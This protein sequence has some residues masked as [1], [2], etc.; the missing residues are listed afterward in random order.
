L[1]HLFNRLFTIPEERLEDFYYH[2]LKF[3]LDRH[4]QGEE[5]VF[6]QYLWENISAQLQVLETK[7]VYDKDHIRNIMNAERLKR[8]RWILSSLD[9]WNIHSSDQPIIERQEQK[10]YALEQDIIRLRSELKVATSLDTPEYINIPKGRV[11][12]VLDL[13]I[14][15]SDLKVEGKELVF[16]E[17]SIVWVKMICK[18]FR[19]DHEDIKFDRVRRYFPEDK[20]NPSARS[21]PI[22]SRQSLFEIKPIRKR[23]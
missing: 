22:P 15:L 7:D 10:I 6:F 2:H 21:A 23:N 17:F 20:R 13:F 14:K 18:Y 4:P 5:K 11:L 12:T 8:L 1:R 19:E 3:Y 9:R 16:S